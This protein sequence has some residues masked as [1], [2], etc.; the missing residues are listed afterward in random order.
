ME[1]T[2]KEKTIKYSVFCAFI[3]LFSLLQNV[4]GLWFEI[5]GARCFFLIPVCVIF[6]IDEDEKISALLGLFAGLLWDAVSV[7]HMGFNSVLLMVS[8]YIV[9][10]LVTF[11]FRD[12]FWI[13][14]A[15]TGIITLL[16]VLLYWLFFVLRK[17]VDGSAFSFLSFYLPCF[18]YTLLMTPLL[19]AVLTP[20]KRKLNKEPKED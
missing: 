8:C 11:I 4:G 19:Y 1:L 7:Q 5:G 17:G 20:L 2:K 14:F 10:A 15:A 9:S 12:T 18:V 13:E 6:S 3:A 16:Y